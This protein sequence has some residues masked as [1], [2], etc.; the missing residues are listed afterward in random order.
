MI[1]FVDD[2]DDL[3]TFF[4]LLTVAVASDDEMIVGG[5]ADIV[6]GFVRFS[7]HFIHINMNRGSRN[8]DVLISG[9]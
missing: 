8:S 1:V 4:V 3:S 7:L 9:L 6:V 5:V 2:D